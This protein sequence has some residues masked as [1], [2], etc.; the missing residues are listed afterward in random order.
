MNLKF[1]DIKVKFKHCPNKQIGHTKTYKTVISGFTDGEAKDSNKK[2]VLTFQE[3]LI[4]VIDLCAE[5]TQHRARAKDTSYI[6][7]NGFIG[8]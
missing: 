6:K 1:S 8:I 4:H 5:I 7:K 3:C 2:G